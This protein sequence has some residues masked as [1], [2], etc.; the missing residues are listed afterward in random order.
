MITDDVDKGVDGA[1]VLYSDVW[2]SMGEEDKFEER[3]KL[4]KPY[5][6][7]MEMVEKHTIQIV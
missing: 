5:Q 7:N 2:V 6:I 3:I 1:D 4:L